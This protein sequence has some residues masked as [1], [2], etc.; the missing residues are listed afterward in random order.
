MSDSQVED[1]RATTG[2]TRVAKPRKCLWKSLLASAGVL[3]IVVLIAACESGGDD[4]EPTPAA[5][6]VLSATPESAPTTPE[7][8][9]TPIP[10]TEAS[11]VAGEVLYES[12]MAHLGGAWSGAVVLRT[13]VITTLSMIAL[14]NDFWFLIDDRFV[15]TV[16]HSGT[17]ARGIDL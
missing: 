2:Q 14:G 8:M 11:P 7:P 10:S 17:S 15:G 6:P 16:N 4:P 9:P 13:N 1:S 5:T 12:D 3:T